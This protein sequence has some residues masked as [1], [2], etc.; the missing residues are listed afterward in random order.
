MATAAWPAWTAKVNIDSN[1]CTACRP[2]PL[3]DKSPKR[4]RAEGQPPF[5]LNYVA[6]EGN[7][8]CMVNGAGLAM[9]T[10]D[11]IKLRAA[12]RPTS[13]TWAAAARSA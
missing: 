4:A 7:I 6:L 9:A 11:I 1:A 2:W 8:G 12:N 3:R 10:M 5:D 13:W